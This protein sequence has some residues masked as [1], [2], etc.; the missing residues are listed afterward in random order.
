MKIAIIGSGAI[1]CL[2]GA[3]LSRNNEILM[4]CRRQQT[5]DSINKSGLTVFEPDNLK[6][7]GEKTLVMTLQ[8]GGGNDLKIAK[9]VPMERILVGTTRHNCVNLDKGNVRH[10][11]SG[12]T[13]IGSNTNSRRVDEV[14]RVLNESDLEAERSDDIQRIIWSKLFL[15]L[16]V[17][18]FTAITKAPIGSM[19]ENEHSWF[20]AEKMICEELMRNQNN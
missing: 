11:G 5:A 16:S 19:I 10:S 12:V 14:V 4:L 2:Y 15:N 13:V 17:N 7:I 20:F 18:S 3:Y 9:Y 1:G 8:N 6:L